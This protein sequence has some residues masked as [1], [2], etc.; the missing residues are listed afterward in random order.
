MTAN[1][2]TFIAEEPG[3][4]NAGPDKSAVITVKPS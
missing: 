4:K 2:H 1:K 3:R